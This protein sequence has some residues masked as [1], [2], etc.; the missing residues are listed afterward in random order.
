MTAKPIV[1]GVGARYAEA[2]ILD[3]ITG[4]PA[5]AFNSGTLVGGTLIEGIKSFTYNNPASQLIQ[6]YGQDR[7]FAQDSLPP[8]AVGSFTITTAKT[9]LSLDAFTEGTKVAVLDTVVQAR[10]GNTDKRGNE[11]QLFVSTFR[12]ALDTQQGSSTFGKLRQW[13]MAVIPSTR[14]VNALQ[15]F[16]QLASV[17]TYEGIPT[18]VATTPWNQTFDATTWGATQAEYVELTTD[19][20][21]VW[22][23]GQGNGT[24]TTFALPKAPIDTAHTHVWV[25]GTIATVSAVNTSV[26]APTVTI[27]S[28]TGSGGN[29]IAV[30][31]ENSQPQ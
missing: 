15:G 23:F 27:S 7:A 13:H 30:L 14:I 2:F 26:A 12:Q 28:A 8:T 1:S 21:P 3:T 18:P 17:K 6:H 19:Y 20:K 10:A 5:V 25:N 11:P 31:I 9:N 22:A 24:L 29:L 16:E 4:L